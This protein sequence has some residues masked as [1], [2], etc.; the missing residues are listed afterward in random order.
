V[1]ARRQP[2]LA[3]QGS[4]HRGVRALGRRPA[5]ELY[6]AKDYE[7]HLEGRPLVLIPFARDVLMG[8]PEGQR[9]VAIGYQARGTSAL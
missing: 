7:M 2:V 3:A 1:G 9:A 6:K 8:V 4:A 5:I